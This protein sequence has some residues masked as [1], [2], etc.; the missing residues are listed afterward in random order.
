MRVFSGLRDIGFY[1]FPLLHII[2]SILYTRFSLRYYNLWIRTV[3][4]NPDQIITKFELT[5]RETEIVM[6]LLQGKSKKVIGEELF[7][8]LHTVKRHIY[9]IYK[10]LNVTGRM[11]IVFLFGDF[12]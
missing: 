2:I 12:V 6:L 8:S 7:V 4:I 3:Q 5:K 1:F 10:K 11:E 9:N